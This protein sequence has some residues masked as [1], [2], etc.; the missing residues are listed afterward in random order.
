MSFNKGTDEL[1]YN[2]TLKYYSATE[3]NELLIHTLTEMNL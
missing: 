2:H 3:M 1:W